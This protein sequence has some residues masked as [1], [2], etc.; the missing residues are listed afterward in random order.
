MEPEHLRRMLERQQKAKDE[1]WTEYLGN[2]AIAEV[3]GYQTAFGLRLTKAVEFPETRVALE[4]HLR[5]FLGSADQTLSKHSSAGK[6]IN[7]IQ[8]ATLMAALADSYFEDSSQ[9]IK[10]AP[11]RTFEEYLESEEAALHF[12]NLQAKQAKPAVVKAT[13]DPAQ[14]P[15]L[16]YKILKSDI[17]LVKLTLENSGFKQTETSNHYSICWLGNINNQA[18]KY[19]FFEN[20]LE[21]QKINHFPM[22][23]EITRKDRLAANMLKLS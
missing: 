23:T 20:L 8:Y 7:R 5:K 13:P 15:P 4:R 9:Q 14:A 1:H 16:L 21:Y 10:I 11:V 18:N 2:H 22:S 19:Q 3:P 17:R 12:P 6:P